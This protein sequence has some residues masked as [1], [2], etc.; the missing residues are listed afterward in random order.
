MITLTGIKVQTLMPVFFGFKFSLY[1]CT[2]HLLSYYTYYTT[3]STGS[4]GT[5]GQTG[6]TG[7]QDKQDKQDS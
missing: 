3:G 1:I 6:D 5:T 4:T 7:Q 2:N